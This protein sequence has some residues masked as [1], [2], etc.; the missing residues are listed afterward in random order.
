MAAEPV[1]AAAREALVQALV[2]HGD[3]LYALA[4]RVTRDP[5]L[6]GDAVQEAFATALQRIG[7]FRGESS[8]G[9][10]LHRIV[11]NKSID[12]LRHRGR[13]AP[14]PDDDAPADDDRLAEVPAWSRPPDQILY[15]EETR[16]ALDAALERLTPQQRAVFTLREMEGLPTDEVAAMMEL[17]PGAVRVHLHR[18]RLR[19]RALLGEHFRGGAAVS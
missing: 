9:T 18:A 14:L 8:L 19:L 10:W 3:R 12:L 11:Y 5:D 1:A 4:L 6:A 7:D 17:E 13:Q 15:G 16:R 2:E